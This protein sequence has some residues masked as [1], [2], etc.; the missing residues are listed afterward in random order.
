VL[1]R[2]VFIWDTEAF[3]IICSE[4]A[5][6]RCKPGKRSAV[7]RQEYCERSGRAGNVK[8]AYGL[9]IEAEIAEGDWSG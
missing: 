9:G 7:F 8:P 3:A 2:A 5:E 6:R 4:G 1:R